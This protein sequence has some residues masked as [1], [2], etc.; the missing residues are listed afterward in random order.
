MSAEPGLPA[1]SRDSHTTPPRCTPEAAGTRRI[2]PF[3]LRLLR[4]NPRLK[5]WILRSD[6][7]HARRRGTAPTVARLV[8]FIKL[9]ERVL[10]IRCPR[11]ECGSMHHD[12]SAGGRRSEERACVSCQTVASWLMLNVSEFKEGRNKRTTT[13]TDTLSQ[14]GYGLV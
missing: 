4:S 13:K 2:H 5:G 11:W 6:P 3:N 9:E 12:K 7:Q 8:L 1:G 10:D 14:N